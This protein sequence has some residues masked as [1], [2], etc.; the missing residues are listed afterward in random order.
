MDSRRDELRLRQNDVGTRIELN[1][2]YR[3][4]RRFA[5][6]DDSKVKKKRAAMQASP[7]EYY[8]DAWIRPTGKTTLMRTVSSPVVSHS[9]LKPVPSSQ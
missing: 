6:V 1:G 3:S 7:C 8:S 2:K 4:S 5:A 9:T